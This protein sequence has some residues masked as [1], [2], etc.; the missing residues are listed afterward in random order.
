MISSS[1]PYVIGEISAI[2]GKARKGPRKE[3]T[4]KDPI[5]EI[6]IEGFELLI[7]L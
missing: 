6:Y 3:E 2:K 7:R 4:D 1:Y 5:M